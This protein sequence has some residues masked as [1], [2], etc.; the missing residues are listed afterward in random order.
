VLEGQ[1]SREWWRDQLAKIEDNTEDRTP[2]F[3]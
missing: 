2:G 3:Q 1:H